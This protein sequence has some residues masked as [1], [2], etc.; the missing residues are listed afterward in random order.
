VNGGQGR[1]R[2]TDTRIFRL[3]FAC[4]LNIY[5][6]YST[7]FILYK[8]V[9]YL[10]SIV[11]GVYLSWLKLNVQRS[12]EIL[13]GYLR[14]HKNPTSRIYHRKSHSA[15]AHRVREKIACTSE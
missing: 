5:Q 14:V 15:E 13:Y 4:V 11:N 8:S 2:T 7:L 1:N 3:T 12:L 10:E 6:G 9:G